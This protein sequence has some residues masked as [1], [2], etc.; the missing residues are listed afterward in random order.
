MI[1]KDLFWLKYEVALEYPLVIKLK[2]SPRAQ[3][4]ASELRTFFYNFLIDFVIKLYL[5]IN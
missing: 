5:W 3:L 2:I 1:I 4:I